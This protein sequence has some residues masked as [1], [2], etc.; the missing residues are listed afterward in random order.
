MKILVTGAS[1]FIGGAIQ[2]ALQ[3][4]GH[5]V[6]PIARR[7]GMDFN[8]LLKPEQWLPYLAGVEVVI[9]A[10]GII[11][12]TRGQSFENL[13]TRAPLALFKASEQ[14]GVKRVIQ[15]SALG[16]DE[17]AFAAY[18]LSKK[19][20]DDGLKASKLAWFILRPSLVYGPGGASDA[21]FRRLAALPV[22]SLPGGGQQRIQPVNVSDVVA[23]V[24][25]CLTAQPTHQVLDVVGPKQYTLE[26]WLQ[27]LR[28]QQGKKPAPTVSISWS[29]VM[30][31]AQLGHKLI[32]VLHPDNM[33]M[34]E[35][36]S[37]AEVEGIKQFLGRMPLELGQSS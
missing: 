9:N 26:T 17:Q 7:Y 29:L 5:E 11:A 6:V 12:E 21:M 36:G 23:T 8:T 1:G 10:V 24:L 31:S 15:I 14:Q 18:Q 35:K 37:V 32:P 2:Q 22:I 33:R 3:Q 19:A 13:H 27:A 4:A 20:A 28:A 34:L 30:L 25:R 16:V